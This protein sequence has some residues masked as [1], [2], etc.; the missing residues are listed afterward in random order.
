VAGYSFLIA[1]GENILAKHSRALRIRARPRD[2]K[3]AF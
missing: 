3:K 1:A 2:I